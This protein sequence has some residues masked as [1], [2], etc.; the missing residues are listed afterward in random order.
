V[1][2]AIAALVA[3]ALLAGCGSS[4]P[5]TLDKLW[6]GSGEQVALV[7][8]SAD[9]ATGDVRVSFVVVD[10]QGRPVYEPRATV[11]LAPALKKAPIQETTAALEEVGPPGSHGDGADITHIYVAH[12]TIPKPGTWWVLARPQGAKIGAVGNLV[13]RTS[14]ASPAVGSRAYSS[15]TPTLASAGGDAAKLTTRVPPDLA[16]LRYSVAD[17]LRAHKPFVVLFATPKF[18]T[19]RTCGPVTDVLLAVQ[20]REAASGIRFIHVEIY[21]D[22]VVSKGPNA[23]VRQWHLPSEPWLFLVGSDGLIKAK[24]EGSFSAGELE[25]ALRETQLAK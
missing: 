9:F 16:L 5:K 1:R 15:R 18:C 22:N 3:L 24:L 4:G 14:T 25:A 6:R 10:H 19:S 2:L 13:V 23:W 12:V 11:W 20:R 21:Q 8:G 7:T 17:S